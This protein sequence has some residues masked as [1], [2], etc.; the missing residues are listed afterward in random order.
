MLY[1]SF[2]LIPKNIRKGKVDLLNIKP[3]YKRDFLSRDFRANNPITLCN[4]NKL[5]TTVSNSIGNM[6]KEKHTNIETLNRKKHIDL[7]SI[8]VKKRELVPYSF[9][10]KRK[11]ENHR[12]ECRTISS[13]PLRFHLK[14]KILTK[15]YKKSINKLRSTIN[16]VNMKMEIRK[17]KLP[18]SKKVPGRYIN[19]ANKGVRIF[20]ADTNNNRKVTNYAYSTNLAGKHL[21]FKEIGTMNRKRVQKGINKD[22]SIPKKRISN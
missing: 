21:K 14:K 10:L 9:L 15:S 11:R 16:Y 20:I 4:T 12:R 19:G 2:T 18:L 8:F 5:V 7:P 6:N 13:T 22:I 3:L 1:K 17:S